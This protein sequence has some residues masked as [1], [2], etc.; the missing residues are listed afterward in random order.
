MTDPVEVVAMARHA[1]HHSDFGAPTWAGADPETQRIYRAAARHDLTALTAAGYAVVPREPSEA[2]HDHRRAGMTEAFDPEPLVEAAKKATQGRW[3]LFSNGHC[4]GG[5]CETSEG[6]T[7]GIA[8]CSNAYRT[9]GE[10]GAN[11]GH[12]AAANPAAILAWAARDATLVAENAALSVALRHA[13]AA[14]AD[15]GDA[16]REE[17][18]DMAWC[19]A[20][21]AKAL[22]VIRAALG[23]RD[24]G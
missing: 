14:L 13:E 20:R 7:A 19:E 6:N 4:V 21:A 8:I 18:D 3:F 16:D 22:P 23:G 15:I 24:D 11:A 9:I 17:G 5:P 12:I 2:M 10:S 1:L